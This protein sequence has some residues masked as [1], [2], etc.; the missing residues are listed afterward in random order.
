MSWH[1]RILLVKWGINLTMRDQRLASH[2]IYALA[3]F[4]FAALLAG[5]LDA[6]WH[7][8]GILPSCGA[9]ASL[10][11]LTAT[12][13]LHVMRARA[14]RK[15]ASNPA[16]VIT[17]DTTDSP[18]VHASHEGHMPSEE[19]P[20]PVVSLS[21]ASPKDALA[22]TGEDSQKALLTPGKPSG[23]DA[24]AAQDQE[25]ALASPTATQEIIPHGAPFD[26]LA[27][28]LEEATNPLTEVR[29]LVGEL[30]ERAQEGNAASPEPLSGL[31]RYALRMLDEAVHQIDEAAALPHV[32]A[33]A[34]SGA[35][36][37]RLQYADREPCPEPIGTNLARLEAALNAILLAANTL[38]PDASIEDAYQLNQGFARSIAA[39]APTLD[40]PPLLE[41]ALPDGEWT[42]RYGISQ[43]IET[44]QLPYRLDVRFRTNVADGNVA[45]EV[46]LTPAEVFPASCYLDGLGIVPTTGDMRQQAAADYALRLALLLAACAFRCSAR[47]KH[48]WVAGVREH[49]GHRNCYFCVDFDR[50]RFSRVDLAHLDDLAETYRS[51]APLMRY[52]EGW[53]RPVK[54]S[55]HLEEERF[56]P[57]RRYVPVSL[58]SRRLT[59]ELAERLGTDHVAGLSIEE[60]DGRSV[61]AGAIMRRLV[62]DQDDRATQRNVRTVMDLAADDPDPT[63]RAAAERVINAFIAGT[64]DMNPVAVGEEF[65]RGDQLT[66]AT[67]RAKI[68]LMQQHPDKALAAVQPVIAAL[69]Q[70]DTYQDTSTISYRYFSS[71][72]ERALYNRLYAEQEQGKSII[73]VPDAYY[74][75]HLIA[76]V[77]E[78]VTGNPQNALSHAERLVALAPLDARARLHLV[79]CLEALGRTDDAVSELCRLLEEAHEPQGLGFGYYRMAAFQWMQGNIMAAR[80]CYQRA[81]QAFPATVPF[82]SMELTVLALQNPEIMQEEPTDDDIDTQ[83]A[84]QGIPVAPTNHTAEVFIECAQASVDAEVF[85]VARNFAAIL[86]AFAGDRIIEGLVRS[87]EDAP[88]HY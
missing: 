12:V 14:T 52:E 24:P 75:A 34:T 69:D 74:E 30:K 43:A 59:G 70:A 66:R 25:I 78:L 84:A 31:E 51:F 36:A 83:L 48:V 60:A 40:E 5:C 27:L 7:Q 49:A 11:L 29:S 55:F 56:C 79:K 9:F 13:M 33:Y 44:L 47:I 20:A 16:T 38:P 77:G 2:V 68:Q 57:A 21:A 86:D 23:D 35:N 32:V 1:D 50:F 6:V 28:R 19:T 63:V 64:L 82:A 42:V 45:M 53:L 65:V 37:I 88:D 15:G 26:D 72:V 67:D 81:M 46:D 62:P 17:L 73:L 76:S 22:P 58:S 54:Q 71:Y 87:I 39:Q 85:P 8:G 4:A 3:E 61:V 10:C 80:A 18:T 41:G